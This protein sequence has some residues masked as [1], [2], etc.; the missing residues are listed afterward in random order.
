[1][2]MA[3]LF[4]SAAAGAKIVPFEDAFFRQRLDRAIN[5]RKGDASVNL[6]G[7]PINLL[8]IGV[9]VCGA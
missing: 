6:V 9:V 1:M 2:F 7:A 8:G 3:R 5:G 4:V